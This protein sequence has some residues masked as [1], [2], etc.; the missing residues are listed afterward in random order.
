[1]PAFI[2]GLHADCKADDRARERDTSFYLLNRVLGTASLLKE[3]MENSRKKVKGP[4]DVAS[5]ILILI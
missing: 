3:Q 2:L 1:V 4:A 5:Y